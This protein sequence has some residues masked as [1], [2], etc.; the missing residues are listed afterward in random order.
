ML[1][2]CG[3][4]EVSVCVDW[5]LTESHNMFSSPRKERQTKFDWFSNAPPPAMSK[6]GLANKLKTVAKS[7]KTRRRKCFV[8]SARLRVAADIFLLRSFCGDIFSLACLSIKLRVMFVV[9]SVFSRQL[10]LRL[11]IYKKFWNET[12]SYWFKLIIFLL[13]DSKYWPRC[14]W[15]DL[16]NNEL[17]FW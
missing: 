1:N 13:T 15:P 2:W 7:E 17:S 3:L 6:Q 4:K 9:S 11:I 8:V 10:W 14:S 12:R 16:L 5:F